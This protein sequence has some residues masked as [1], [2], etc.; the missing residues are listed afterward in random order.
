MVYFRVD[1]NEKIASGHVMRCLSIARALKKQGEES[2][3]L[4]A[5]A[6]ALPM[7][8]E[9]GFPCICL[10]SVWDRPETE[11]EALLSV[12]RE[13]QVRLLFL[14]SYY[15]TPDYLRILH[16]ETRLAYLD[17]LNRFPYE[18][19]ILINYLNHYHKSD[20]SWVCKNT[21]LLLGS[22]FAPLREEFIQRERCVKEQVTHVLITTGGGDTYHAA[23]QY[24]KAAL[25]EK[26]LNGLQFFVVAGRFHPSVERLLQL[27]EENPEVH[28]CEKV[29]NMAELMLQCEIGISAGGTTL[30][31]L[32]ACCLPAVCFGFADNQLGEI[33]EFGKQGVF[34]NVGDIRKNQETAIREMIE[35]TV[36][37][38]EDR[39]LREACMK[40]MKTVT[41]GNGAE[42]IA[43]ELLKFRPEQSVSAGQ[44]CP[45]SA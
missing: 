23:E 24:L 18:V 44:Q 38:R 9:Q 45:S 12:I 7:L 28:V 10:D 6:Y 3:F 22:S 19:D 14:D 36:L 30:Y 15:V 37:L 34:L 4:T 13:N 5:D 35:K 43:R 1:A 8:K 17:D 33:E 31:E 29:K 11:L 41:D 26:R 32:C 39:E 42:R 40:K 27:E 2:C 21:K 25:G 16:K 20:Y